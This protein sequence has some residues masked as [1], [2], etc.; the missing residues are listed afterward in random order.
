[1]GPSAFAGIA[2]M[3][4]TLPANA[5]IATKSRK[6]QMA[7]MKK[8]DDRVKLMNEIL[9]GIKV[10]KLYA[11]EKSFQNQIMKIRQ[12]EIVILKKAAY[13]SATSSFLMTCAPFM[14]SLVRNRAIFLVTFYVCWKC[15]YCFDTEIASIQK[16]DF[17]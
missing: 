13:L 10:L 1:L 14:V 12:E 9:T 11:W 4:F 7:Q 5:I 15:N 17:F 8:K 2:V 3:I 16:N 6:L